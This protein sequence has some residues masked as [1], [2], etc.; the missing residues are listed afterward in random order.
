M[1][2]RKRKRIGLATPANL[3]G[4]HVDH[5]RFW[6]VK[7]AVVEIE[8]GAVPRKG[9][10]PD[11]RCRLDRRASTG[12]HV[13]ELE[14]GLRVPDRDGAEVGGAYEKQMFSNWRCQNAQ[15]LAARKVP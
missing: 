6:F 14:L 2:G 5:G 3:Q 1:R 12:R 11:R 7:P 9:A 4:S 15:C 10:A 13:D 8:K